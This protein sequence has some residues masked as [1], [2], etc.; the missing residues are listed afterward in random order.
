MNSRRRFC[1]DACH[2]ALL[3]GALGPL[4]ACGGGGSSSPSAPSSTGPA[5]ALPMLTATLV[6]NTVSLPID[7]SSPLATVGRTAFVT[8]GSIQLLVARIADT[9]FT[10]LTA[11]CTHEGCAITGFAN[12]RYVCPCH[13]SAFDTSGRVVVGPA[14]TALRTFPTS[15]SGGVLVITVA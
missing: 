15:F 12:S 14:L 3:A 8:A 11:V 4:A 2:A 13:G 9:T 1:A 10:A 7:A 6:G 5:A